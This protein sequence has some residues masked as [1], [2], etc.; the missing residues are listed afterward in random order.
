MPVTSTTIRPVIVPTKVGEENDNG[1]QA[2]PGV[3]HDNY[4]PIFPRGTSVEYQSKTHKKWIIA[5]VISFDAER[6]FY[7]LDAQPKAARERVRVLDRKNGGDELY[8]PAGKDLV[9]TADVDD[10]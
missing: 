4:P 8:G 10:N 5:K 9:L 2:V 7:Q 1:K 6:N 3:A